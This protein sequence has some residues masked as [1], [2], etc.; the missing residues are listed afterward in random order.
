MTPPAPEVWVGY[1]LM[2]V[3]MN[4]PVINNRV[5]KYLVVGGAVVG[6]MQLRNNLMLS[7]DKMDVVMESL[8]QT[9]LAAQ[10]TVVSVK[11]ED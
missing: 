9:F 10:S 11:D 5:Y 3:S 4:S 6:M 2:I 7:C 8:S 1:P